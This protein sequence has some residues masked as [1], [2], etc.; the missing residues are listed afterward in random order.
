MLVKHKKKILTQ[1]HISHQ[2]RKQIVFEGRG[3]VKKEEN[4]ERREEWEENVR[5][6]PNMGVKFLF[7][8]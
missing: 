8:V 7:R 4:E 3:N 6:I 1:D 5:K 2:N